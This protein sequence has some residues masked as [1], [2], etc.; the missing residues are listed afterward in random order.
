MSVDLS[1]IERSACEIV[2]LLREEAVSPHD[3]LDTLAA[4]VERVE[5]RVN[6][7]PTLCFE[8]AHA[9]ADALLKKPVGERGL[10]CGLPVP[11]KDLTDAD[12]RKKKHFTRILPTA[13]ISHY[14]RL[15]SRATAIAATTATPQPIKRYLRSVGTNAAHAPR[16]TAIRTSQ[17]TSPPRRGFMTMDSQWLTIGAVRKSLAVQEAARFKPAPCPLPLYLRCYL[18]W[19]PR[20][21]F[22]QRPT[23]RMDPGSN[24]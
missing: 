18:L 17:V 15:R 21:R 3:L 12:R 8:R 9:H 5:P 20:L 23:Q 1:L 16:R 7:L 6:A 22:E 24:E 4:Q 2:D 11:I 10:L 13:V 19:H 14:G